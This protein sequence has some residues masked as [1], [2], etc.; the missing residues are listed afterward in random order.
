MKGH[1]ECAIVGASRTGKSDAATTLSNFYQLGNVTDAKTS[2]QAGMI[3]GAESTNGGWRLKWGLIPRNHKS[4]VILDE[5]SGMPLDVM[6]K[7][8]PV[9]SQRVAKIEK[10]VS[11]SAPAKTRLM[12]IGN[13]RTGSDNRSR[14]LAE[15]PNGVEVILDLF[16]SD[17]DIARFDFIVLIPEGEKYISELDE[18]GNLPEPPPLPEELREIIRWV[19]SRSSD[20]VKFENKVEK[21]IEYVADLLNKDFG[22]S[23]K[24][25]GHE[26]AKK[27]ARMAI[28]VAACCF[29][30]DGSGENIIVTKDH[31]DWVYKYL[32][33]LY[34]NPVFRLREFVERERK[35]TE[36]DDTIIQRVAVLMKNEPLLVSELM[37]QQEC[38]I[39]HL[40][41]IANDPQFGKL[42]NAMVTAGLV[43]TTKSSM[44]KASQRLKK[45]VRINQGTYSKH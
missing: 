3:G 26:G 9:R 44:I 17:E 20:Q 8:T 4:L 7:L 21:Y 43:Q 2:S 38:N 19:W 14:S 23:V 5:V 35:F 31:V 16:G 41:L 10:I 34:D 28:S 12:W 6:S 27:I 33:S 42:L 36:V 30:C 15:Y 25:I 24:I 18:D 13:P 40:K 32:V 39:N 29:S 45:A 22:S 37:I 1:P 11:G